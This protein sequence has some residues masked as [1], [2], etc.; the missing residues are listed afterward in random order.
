MKKQFLFFVITLILININ[1]SATEM[2]A[3]RIFGAIT[4]KDTKAPIAGVNVLIP[5]LEKG[6]LTDAKG[7]FI[8]E[9]IPDLIE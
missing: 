3:G 5:M 1:L 4:D 6:T 7:H 2:K 9:N 8:L